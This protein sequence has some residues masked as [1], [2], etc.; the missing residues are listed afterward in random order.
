MHF[1]TSSYDYVAALYSPCI[2]CTTSC[3]H[4][5]YLQLDYCCL[6]CWTKKFELLLFFITTTERTMT[7]T[8]ATNVPPPLEA[9]PSPHYHS[10]DDEKFKIYECGICFDI[11]DT[12]V[13][14]GGSCQTRFCRLCLE[15]VA[16]QGG[17]NAKCS[18]CRTPFTL[19]S[20][21]VDEALQQKMENCMETIICPFL[22]CGKNIPIKVIK[23]HEKQCGHMKMKCKFSEWGCEWV[24]KKRIWN[25]MTITSVSSV[26]SWDDLSMSLGRKR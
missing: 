19:Q 6:C 8:T 9:I 4:S 15:H 26:M 3:C 14:C 5:I 10:Y 11:M 25:I 12:P 1:C 24:G 23:Q 13:G 16:K 22:G 2:Y 7:A 18:H 21:Q 17:R 20:I